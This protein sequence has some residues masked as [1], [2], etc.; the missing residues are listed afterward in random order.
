MACRIECKSLWE[1]SI[2]VDAWFVVRMS[3]QPE[4]KFKDADSS[5]KSER[6]F[7]R[8]K[9]K[10]LN[11]LLHKKWLQ[12]SS[13]KKWTG[14]Y[15]VAAFPREWF[16]ETFYIYFLLQAVSFKQQT[17][18]NKQGEGKD[19]SFY[20]RY[21]ISLQPAFVKWK[22]LC[23][24]SNSMEILDDWNLCWNWVAKNQVQLIF[25]KFIVKK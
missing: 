7:L 21:L 1:E 25:N 5:T 16:S 13:N 10:N 2:Y 11:I 8:V 24:E 6:W 3:R 20:C 17:E 9:H 14:I 22:F 4:L 18:R 19:F 12:W 15:I 23:I